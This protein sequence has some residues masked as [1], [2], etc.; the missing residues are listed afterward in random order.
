MQKNYKVGLTGGI[1]TGKST[2]AKI[3]LCLGVPVY[4]ADFHARE[5]MNLSEGIKQKIIQHFGNNAYTGDKIN[6]DYLSGKVFNQPD[7]LNKLNSIVHP[8]VAIHFEQWCRNHSDHQYIIKEAALLFETGSYQYLD[9]ILL[10]TS[11]IALRI[12]RIKKRDP[13]RNENEIKAIID[14]QWG[15]DKKIAQSNFVIKNDEVSGMIIPQI[16]AIHQSLLE[17]AGAKLN[18]SLI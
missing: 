4:D 5:L 1:G 16:L 8:E 15:D 9:S 13:F 17:L 6:R 11:P 3:F 14:R 12:E 18:G 2:I 7:E 10:V